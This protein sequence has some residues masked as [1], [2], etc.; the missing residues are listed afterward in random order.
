MNIG[1][2]IAR[3]I[4]NSHAKR[5]NN[6]VKHNVFIPFFFSYYMK[7]ILIGSQASLRSFLR[8]YFPSTS[9]TFS[10]FLSIFPSPTPTFL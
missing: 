1:I 10:S 3:T 2:A 7:F 9:I 5:K 8:I 6:G 4:K